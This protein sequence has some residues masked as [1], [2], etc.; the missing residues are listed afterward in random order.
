MRKLVEL[1][2]LEVLLLKGA[3]GLEMMW[4]QGVGDMGLGTLVYVTDLRRVQS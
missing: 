1:E 3:R 4:T 2:T